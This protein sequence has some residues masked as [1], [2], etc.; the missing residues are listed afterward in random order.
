MFGSV[1]IAKQDGCHAL[2]VASTT[3]A[4]APLSPSV[5]LVSPEFENLQNHSDFAEIRDNPGDI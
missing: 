4:Y 3:G 2:Q 1:Q 5:A